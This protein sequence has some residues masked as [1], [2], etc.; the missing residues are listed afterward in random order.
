MAKGQIEFNKMKLNEYTNFAGAER[1]YNAKGKR[2]FRILLD[3][4]T[5]T[6]FE[7]E[8]YILSWQ[9]AEP[10]ALPTA[11]IKCNLSFETPAGMPSPKVWQVNLDQDGKP[12]NKSLL[13]PDLVGTLDHL[14]IL[15]ATVFA[16]GSTI[17]KK[18]PFEGMKSLYAD[19]VFAYVAPSKL[20]QEVDS[21][22]E[23]LSSEDLLDMVPLAEDD[24]EEQPF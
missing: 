3:N 4:E 10:G 8:K 9:D 16:H 15:Y 18:G 20:R 14:D 21:I 23:V 19:E 12:I 6:W 13:K 17:K 24:S 1:N 5:A 2:N 22:P 11:E 7:N